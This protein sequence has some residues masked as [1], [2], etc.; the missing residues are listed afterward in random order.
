[1]DFLPPPQQHRLSFGHD[2]HGAANLTAIHAVGPEQF[3]RA[4]RAIRLIFA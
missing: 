1:M 3:R 2:P 4:V